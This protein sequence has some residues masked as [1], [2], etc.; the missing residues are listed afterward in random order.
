MIPRPAYQFVLKM[1][2]G[3]VDDPADPGGLTNKGITQATYA[4]W[5][6]AKGLPSR[7]VTSALDTEISAIYWERYWRPAQCEK[8]QSFGLEALAMAH[9][10]CAVNMGV[11]RAIRTLQAALGV[12]E[13][14]VYGPE[15]EGALLHK[16]EH[17]TI[18]SY[19]EERANYYH[20]LARRRPPLRKFLN[21]WLARLRNLARETGVAIQP[22]FAKGAEK[23]PFSF[24]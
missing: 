4:S 2:G 3:V 12:T 20:R 13:D 16:G 24:E 15:T 22:S 14:G 21:G 18:L 5:R 6:K 23:E 10:D 1:E 11:L 9:F 19:L 7:P 17:A 8:I